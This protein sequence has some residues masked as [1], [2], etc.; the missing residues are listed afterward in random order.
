MHLRWDDLK[1][2][3][4]VY[5]QGSLSG[6]ARLLKLGQPTLSRRIAELEETVGEA[7]FHRQNSGVSL[8]VT[9]QKLLPAVQNMAEWANEANLGIQKQ[10]FLPEGKVRIAAPPG[11]AYELIA[12]WAAKIRRDHPQIQIEAL[13]GV[14]TLNLGRGEADLSLRTEKPTDA[15]LLCVDEISSAVR[16]FASKSYA[17]QHPAVSRPADLDWICWAAPY[18][19]LLTNRALRALIPNFKPAFTSDDF[20]VQIA[21]CK[22]GVGAMLLPQLLRGYADFRELQ[23]LNIDLDSDAPGNLYLVCHKRHHQL[24]K[25]Q[26]VINFISREFDSMRNG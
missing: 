10:R 3:L 6:A 4:T 1:L 9:G 24:P 14:E 2:F 25:V 5:E 20:I 23:E 26:W 18:D 16:V 15:D 7:L 21:A 13:S 17:A 8:T 22:A 12:P 11:I 19:N